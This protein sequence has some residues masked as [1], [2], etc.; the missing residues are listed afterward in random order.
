MEKYISLLRGINVSGKNS[1]K[2]EALKTM[3]TN[4]GFTNVQTY[5]QSGNIVFEYKKE[6][7]EILSKLIAQ[8]ILATFGHSVPVLTLAKKDFTTIIENN[9]FNK[10]V[11]KDKNFLHVT[12]LNEKPLQENFNKIIAANYLPD[13]I[14]LLEKAI[15]LYCPNGY[16]N[17]KLHNSFLE[18]K[19]KATATTR[20]WKTMQTLARIVSK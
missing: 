10:D 5:I 17:T 4:I 19:L 1:I 14:L 20:N 6:K 9:Q 3:C 16:G 13:E 8:N 7:T 15:Y 2:M 12:I 18:N 11:K